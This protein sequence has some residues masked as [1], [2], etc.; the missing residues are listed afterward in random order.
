MQEVKDK[1]ST[2]INKLISQGTLKSESVIGAFK[3]ITRADF[4]LPADRSQSDL[5]EPLSIGHGQTIS[6]PL[7]VAFMLELLEPAPGERILDVGCGSGWTTAL[8]SCLV[9]PEGRVYGL[10]VLPELSEFAAANVG[11]Y[12]FIEKGIAQIRQGDGKQGLP[13]K[14]PF[15]KI[16]VSA[17][18]RFTPPALLAQLETGGVM[19]IPVGGQFM[20]QDILKITKTGTDKFDIAR[21]PGFVFV[22][23]I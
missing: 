6:Q 13:E 16:L 2:L 20:S 14:A 11:K 22:P 15:A 12:G 7:T 17:A 9:E 10:E 5:N 18:A 19:V 21:Y 1:E 8:L 3:R 4:L 23:L